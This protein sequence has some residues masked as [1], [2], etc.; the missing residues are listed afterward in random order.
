MA[1]AVISNKPPVITKRIEDSLFIVKTI[2]QKDLRI[3]TI[4]ETLPFRIRFTSVKVPGVSPQ[5]FP[6]IPLQV[7]GFSNYII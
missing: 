3:T 6:A 4:N 1:S 5:N 2:K 7:I